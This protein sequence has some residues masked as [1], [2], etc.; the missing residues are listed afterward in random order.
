MPENGNTSTCE[1]GGF[2]SYV[3]KATRVSQIQLAVNFAR[4]LNIR[5][6]VHNTG[7]DFLG[8]STGAGAL[9]IWTHHLKSVDLIKDYKSFSCM[10]STHSIILGRPMH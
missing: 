10:Y 8:K 5:F 9:S 3:V 4:N 1:L 2:P 7:H 6:V